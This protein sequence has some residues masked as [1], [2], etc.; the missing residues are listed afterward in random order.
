MNNTDDWVNGYK[1]NI[2]SVIRILKIL[3]AI[4]SGEKTA[5]NYCILSEW[6]YEL[7]EIFCIKKLK[8]KT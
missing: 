7:S 1:L 2:F 3:Q 5:R 6:Y 4:K 8:R